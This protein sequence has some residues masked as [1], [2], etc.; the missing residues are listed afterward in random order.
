MMRRGRERTETPANGQRPPSMGF[1]QLGRAFR[2]LRNYRN[3]AIVAV[4]AL[5]ISIVAQLLV[6]QMV[7]NILDTVA[8]G[9]TL[10]QEGTE[11]SQQAAMTAAVQAL[12]WSIILILIFALAR[13][14]FAFMQSF[15]AEKMSQGIAF[16]LRNDLFAKIQRLSFSYHD[17]NRTGQLMVRATDDVEKLRLFLGQGLLII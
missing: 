15:S 17:R 9:L 6:P 5:L 14:L 10:Q 16:D 7:Q 8:Q 4:G 12:I 3:T 13:G 1:K 11:T 2:Y